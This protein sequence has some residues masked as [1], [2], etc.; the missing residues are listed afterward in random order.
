MGLMTY[1]SGAKDPNADLAR[2]DQILQECWAER[3]GLRHR[4]V[5]L[6]TLSKKRRRHSGERLP[7]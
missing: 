4:V 3:L 6:I 5:A 2:T 7:T 1:H